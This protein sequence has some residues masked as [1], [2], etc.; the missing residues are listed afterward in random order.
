M[1]SSFATCAIADDQSEENHYILCDRNTGCLAGIG[2]TVGSNPD[3]P[4]FKIVQ[5][6]SSLDGAQ[7][8]VELREYAGLDGQDHFAGLTLTSTHDGVEKQFTFPTDLPTNKTA[9][10]SVV[11]AAVLYPPG[12][13]TPPTIFQVYISPTGGVVIAYHP[14]SVVPARFLATDGGTVNFAGTD[15]VTY[16]SLPA[17]GSTSLFR[18]GTI[19]QAALPRGSLPPG[20][21][22]SNSGH[23]YPTAPPVTAVEYYNAAEDHYFISA[24]APDI[25]ALDSGRTAGWTRTGETFGVGS[26]ALTDLDLEYRYKG[27]AVCRFYIPPAYGSSHYFSASSDECTSVKQR[28]PNFVLESDAAFFATLPD[29]VTGNCPVMPGFLD[30][31]I[32]LKPIYRLW[33]QRSDTNHR[34]TT[35]LDIRDLMI[36]RGWLPE[37][38]GPA[39]VV[40]CVN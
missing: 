19:G 8:F 1:A 25:D 27:S 17:D 32:Q 22:F 37:G 15:E 20:A 4:T 33:N 9:N 12:P 5:V 30:G 11:V 18:D 21:P 6:Y 38:F 16:A 3:V 7:Q 24:S 2:Y 10:I 28:F 14:N 23:T 36:E 40:M 39:G 31:D 34:Y 26:R 13:N 29:P 35:D